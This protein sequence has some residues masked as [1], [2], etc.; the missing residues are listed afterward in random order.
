M[1]LAHKVLLAGGVV[2][3]LGAG[4]YGSAL[5]ADYQS[6]P[7]ASADAPPAWPAASAIARGDGATLVMLAHPRCP[8]TRASLSELSAILGRAGRAVSAHVLFVLPEAAGPDWDVEGL[9]DQARA[10]PGLDVRGDPGGKE[11]A[12]FG[13]FTSGQVLLY[14]RGGAL[15]FA[16]GITRGRGHAGR[17]A[18]ADAVAAVLRGEGARH[19]TGVFG[20]ALTGDARPFDEGE[21]R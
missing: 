19:E 16:G 9:W 8:C 18:G 20:C 21:A 1:K 3:W 12:R 15:A 4:A 7:G 5:L 17:N 6:T 10:I 11:A 2:A 13:A 14:D